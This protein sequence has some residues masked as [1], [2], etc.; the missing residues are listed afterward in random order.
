[1]Q[2]KEGIVNRVARSNLVTLNLE[3]FYRVGDRVLIDLKDQ[4]FQGLV[5][6]EK[7]FRAFVS[8]HDWVQ[9]E[10]KFVAVHCSADAIIPVWAYMLVGLSLRP[11]AEEIH[12]GD[13]S[14]LEEHLFFEAL[15]KENWLKYKDARVVVKG[16][17]VLPIPSGAFME[18]SVRLQ[19]H[20]QSLLYGE[21]CS[22][23]PLY[24]R[25]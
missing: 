23:V 24:K 18:V 16:C 20:V 2:E 12:F 3:D 21:P 13:L 4:L 19:P 6:R 14:A 5:L 10:G 8:G 15:G 11:F 7:D 17:G 9:Y 22:T 1:M 25:K